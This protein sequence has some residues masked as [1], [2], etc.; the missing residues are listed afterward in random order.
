MTNLLAN[1]PA[2]PNIQALTTTRT[3]GFS[4][5]P[6]DKNNLALHVGDKEEHV[7]ANRSALVSTLQLPTN[8][9]WLEQ[10]H[11]NLCVVVE[12]DTNRCADAA[13]T[14][15]I[16]SPLAIMTA[17]CL[18]IV[19]C[20]RNGSEIAAIHAGWRGLANGIIENTLAKMVNRSD[21]LLAWIGPAIC[22]AC[23]EVG[24]EMYQTYVSRYPFTKTT[25]R[26]NGTHRYANLPK[27]AE[28]IFQ[29]QGV[30]AV[31]QSA[32]CSFE[33]KNKFYSYRR[34][35]QTG[36]MATLIWFND[37][38]ASPNDQVTG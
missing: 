27:M 32:A 26:K 38:N 37:K 21:L 28:L 8:P 2:P 16:N 1:W 31:F 5:S 7:H 29:A 12:E 9:I 19:L 14:R 20:D 30:S 10:T 35:A 22:Q 3:L 4:V 25:F 6:Y 17:D 18:P 11:S 15:R 34:E 13:V 24:D 33:L 23:Y 36:R